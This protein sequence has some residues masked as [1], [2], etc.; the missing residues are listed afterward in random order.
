M[1]IHLCTFTVTKN[2]PR[3]E[4]QCKIKI[5]I[6]IATVVIYCNQCHFGVITFM[7]WSV[8]LPTGHLNLAS[9]ASHQTIKRVL[10]PS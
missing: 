6:T 5:I 10:L 9:T 3:S 2:R 4:H 7:E 8:D 1:F